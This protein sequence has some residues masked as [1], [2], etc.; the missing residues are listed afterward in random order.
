MALPI[1][2]KALEQ[3]LATPYTTVYVSDIIKPTKLPK[4]Q[5]LW[6]RVWCAARGHGGI[7]PMPGDVYY[8]HDGLCKRCGSR[9]ALI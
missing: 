1:D 7:T 4:L 2:D 9:V 5:P 3:L 8:Q 6:R